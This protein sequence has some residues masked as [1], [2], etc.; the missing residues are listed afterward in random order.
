MPTQPG[1]Q[2]SSGP[3][4]DTDTTVLLGH[5]ASPV[6][7]PEQRLLDI[8]D[9]A[10][11]LRGGVILEVGTATSVTANHPGARLWD[12]GEQLLLPGFVDCHVHFPQV[13]MIA[14]PGH[15]LQG[16]LDNYA[17]PA[18]ARFSNPG[19]CAVTADFFT[20]QLV[21]NGV[22]TAAVYATVHPESVTALFRA[23]QKRQLRLITGKVCMDRNAPAELLDTPEQAVEQSRALIERWHGVDR[24]EYAVTPRFAPTSSPRQ[25]ELLGE[26]AQQYPD[27]L[28]QT[29]L[30][31][32]EGECAWVGE[33]Y[34]QERDYT[35]VY[36]RFGLV[37]PRSVFGHGIYLSDS[38][39]RRLGHAN[40]SIVHCPTSNLFLGSGLFSYHRVAEHDGLHIG[41]GSDVGAGTSLSP[42]LTLNE[43]YKVSRLLGDP[44][45]TAAALRLATL[46]GAE[47]L[48]LGDRVGSLEAGKDA[49]IVVLDPAATPLLRHRAELTTST[50]ELL[51]A[52]MMLGDDRAITGTVVNGELAEG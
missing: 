1:R 6:S 30:A 24:L 2:V 8:A 47:A 13:D 4:R 45:T 50:E 17:Y 33:L 10:V 37:R 7:G 46:G 31:E 3:S 5:V 25:L 42:F 39:L 29:H 26:L 49:D 23:A 18:E 41:L 32:N 40:A 34:P 11:A 27:M 38:E 51:F 15:Q 12:F 28:V 44:I 35:A 16:W 19:H 20:D 14:S 48:G 43:A 52:L 36:E 21:A 9:G 22:T